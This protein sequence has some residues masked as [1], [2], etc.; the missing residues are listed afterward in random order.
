[1]VEFSDR[2]PVMGN[3]VESPFEFLA[4]RIIKGTQSSAVEGKRM[5]TKGCKNWRWDESKAQASQAG[6]CA[7]LPQNNTIV[8]RQGHF[9][10]LTNHWLGGRCLSQATILVVRLELP[11]A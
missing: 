8:M 2:M 4:R 1:M 7:V 3:V 10:S 6:A 11:P 5:E 9:R